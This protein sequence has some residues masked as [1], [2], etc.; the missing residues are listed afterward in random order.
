MKKVGMLKLQLITVIGVSKGSIHLPKNTP[1]YP[2][3]PKNTPE[4]PR[5]PLEYPRRPY[6]CPRIPQ[7]I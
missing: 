2:G 3:I 5:I 4:Y 1:E 6:E 7:N